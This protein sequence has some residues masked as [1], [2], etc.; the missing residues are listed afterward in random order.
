MLS[1]ND[2]SLQIVPMPVCQYQI[3]DGGPDGAPLHL[4]TLGQTVRDPER[5]LK[6]TVVISI[7]S[8]VPQVDLRVWDGG[9]ILHDR[10]FLHCRW[11]KW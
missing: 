4:A 1:L 11:W 7:V 2:P 10:A 6:I 8:G 9:H 5:K 3:L